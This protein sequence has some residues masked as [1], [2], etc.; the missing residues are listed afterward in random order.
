VPE[1]ADPG[2]DPAQAPTNE[3]PAEDEGRAAGEEVAKQ[4]RLSVAATLF[5]SAGWQERFVVPVLA[6][7]VAL[8]IGALVIMFTND[9]VL[10]EWSSFFRDPIGAL[11][12][13]GAA[14]SEAYEALFRGALGS[15]GAIS[16]TLLV[17][18]PLM[19]TGLAVA[20][21]F[22]AGLFN[23]GAEGQFTAGAILGS[24]AGFSLT[25]LPGPVH[26]ALVVV[27]GLVGGAAWGA[28]PGILKA[29]TGAH[30]VITTIMLNFVAGFLALYFL[31]TS[32]FR[33][34]DRFD[35]ISKPVVEAFPRIFGSG[36][37][38]HLGLI[39][40]LAVA[41]VIA[42]LLRRTT[43]GFEFQAVGANPDAAR[44]AGMSPTKTFILA[45]ALAGGVAGL[46]ASNQL[47]GVIPSLTPGFS[48]GFGFDGIAIA[49]LGRARPAG[50]VA[51]AILF[52]ILRAGSR[53][54]QAA[55]QTP[56]DI[57]TVITA[58]VIMFVAAPPLVRAIFRLRGRKAGGLEV[59]SKGW[60]G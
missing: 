7:V 42:W 44:A 11:R 35:P 60:G 43:I 15:T 6:V 19:Y 4:E 24:L 36:N 58:L 25:G 41:A 40:A 21:G 37:R 33:R 17:A 38:I 14:V 20:I 49:L 26:V 27:A 50:V 57:V 2:G 31:Q 16:E 55:T 48:S 52:G 54:M 23:I 39:V 13:S 9:E 18:I 59:L 56:T 29:R 53:S 12:A 45:M 22:R 10:R 34:P 5:A 3:A 51:A 47:L 32:L 46:G 30:E 28:I 1:P 8:A